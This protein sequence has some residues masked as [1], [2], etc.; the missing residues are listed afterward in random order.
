MGPYWVRHGVV[1]PIDGLKTGKWGY[2]VTPISGAKALLK[3]AASGS[4]AKLLP[5]KK[6]NFQNIWPRDAKLCFPE[7]AIGFRNL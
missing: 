2:T 4:I 1:T 5:F 7:D 6:K 3:P